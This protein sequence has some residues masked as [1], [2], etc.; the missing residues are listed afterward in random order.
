MVVLESKEATLLLISVVVN[1]I[2]SF[3]LANPK[4]RL[5]FFKKDFLMIKKDLLNV[6]ITALIYGIILL[7]I[8]V[9]LFTN[10]ALYT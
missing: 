8:F 3:L 1:A 9:T 6:L 2:L 10:I 7:L 4:Y 5:K